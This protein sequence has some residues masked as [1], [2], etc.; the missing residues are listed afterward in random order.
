M[1][2]KV[3]IDIVWGI[4]I[5]NTTPHPIIFM[6]EGKLH[7]V[8]PCGFL[9]NAEPVNEYVRNEGG[10]EIFR[11]VFHPTSEGVEFL[12]QIPDDVIVV[13]SALAAQAY[14]GKVKMLVPCRGV[15]RVPINQKRMRHDKFSIY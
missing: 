14:P 6:N 12:E 13:G 4:K 8:Q 3:V 11:T 1:K 15:A 2:A 9:L 7:E 10:A 5:L